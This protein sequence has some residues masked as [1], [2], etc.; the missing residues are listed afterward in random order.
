MASSICKELLNRAIFYSVAEIVDNHF[1]T[2]WLLQQPIQTGF[3]KQRLPSHEQLAVFGREG[4]TIF[5]FEPGSRI[6]EKSPSSSIPTLF[7]P[8][9]PEEI[10]HVLRTV[11]PE[12]HKFFNKYSITALFK[13]ISKVN[14]KQEPCPTVCYHLPNKFIY[15]AYREIKRPPIRLSGDYIAHATTAV[16]VATLFLPGF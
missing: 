1:K 13:P 7:L 8:A 14:K 2:K 6:I 16:K 10:E 11:L 3:V 9:T 12:M 4:T 5:S 15:H